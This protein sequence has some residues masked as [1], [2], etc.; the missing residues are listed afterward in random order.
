[1][2]RILFLVTIFLLTTTKLYATPPVSEC[3]ISN[4]T[5]VNTSTCYT[6]PQMYSTKIYKILLCTEAP[7]VMSLVRYADITPGQIDISKC[8]AVLFDNPSGTNFNIVRGSST[9]MGTSRDVTFDLNAT[10][11]H[12]IIVLENKIGIKDSKKFASQ[13]MGRTGQ[14]PYCW[15]LSGTQLDS[16]IAA[17]SFYDISN[18]AN[19]VVE[20]GTSP[21][22]P[23]V[24]YNTVQLGNMVDSDEHFTNIRIA[25]IDDN[26]HVFSDVNAT[27]KLAMFSPLNKTIKLGGVREID[28]KLRISN[29]VEISMHGSANPYNIPIFYPAPYTVSIESN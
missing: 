26:F 19:W 10:Y 24:F 4:N 11:T 28:M 13:V 25:S 20:C 14:G 8:T 18:R 7:S 9:H 22:S 5:I 27:H 23:G 21:G 29:S 6:T 17:S 15:S 3:T 16:T 12:S 2:N 1:M